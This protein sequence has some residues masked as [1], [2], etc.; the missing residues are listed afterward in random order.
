MT[1]DGVPTATD[2]ENAVNGFHSQLQA[3]YPGK[4]SSQIWA[5]QGFSLMNGHTDSAE[6]FTQSDFQT[7]LNFALNNHMGRYTYW[8]VNR[9]HECPGNADQLSGTCSGVTQNDWDFTKF[10]AAFANGTTV[11]PTVTPTT[12]TTGGTTTA[13][14][15]VTGCS[16]PTYSS[17]AVYTNGM[18]VSYNGHT[19]QAKWWTQGEA[20]ST[21]GS[22]VWQDLGPCGST[23]TT[24]ATTTTPVVTTTTP[25]V[26]TTTPVATTTTSG[27][28]AWAPNVAYHIGDLV[29]YQGKTYKCIQAHTSQTGWEPPN[30]PALW[31]AQ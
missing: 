12:T 30:V 13:T 4:S 2:A 24:P 3:A 16:A 1:F 15:P 22:G 28:P 29:T 26:T 25:V 20:P 7:L 14:T 18:Q 8:S 19:W 11:I 21:G 31:Q 6:H 10:T 9:D 23:T 17:T 27:V 5:M